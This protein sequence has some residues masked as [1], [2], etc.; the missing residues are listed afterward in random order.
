VSTLSLKFLFRIYFDNYIFESSTYSCTGS[1]VVEQLAL[2][3]KDKGSNPPVR[4]KMKGVSFFLIHD[5]NGQLRGKF[6]AILYV[7]VISGID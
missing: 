2:N 3:S 6:G 4:L 7:L 5:M 1:T